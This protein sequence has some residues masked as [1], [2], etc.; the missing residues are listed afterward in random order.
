[1]DPFK[2]LNAH[3][4]KFRNKEDLYLQLAPCDQRSEFNFIC[5]VVENSRY[6][7]SFKNHARESFLMLCS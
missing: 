6:V 5:G 7:V 4:N 2:T 3:V 1:M